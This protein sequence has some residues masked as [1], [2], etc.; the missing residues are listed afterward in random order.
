[1]ET[2]LE[3]AAV[4]PRY[5]RVVF[6]VLLCVSALM[7]IV[8]IRLRER[9]QDRLDAALDT[10]PL[11]APA[12]TQPSSVTL[13]LANDADGSTATSMRQLSLPAE[14]HARAR[15]LLNQL[16]TEYAKP[17]SAHPIATNPGID[18]VFLM[19]IAPASEG[20]TATPPKG[21]LAVVNLSGGLIQVHPSGIEPETLTLL[22]M[23]TTLNS[24]MP[25]ITQVRFL[26][27]G[28]PRETL[29]GHADLSR[30]YLASSSATP[31]VENQP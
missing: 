11:S 9:A 29:A 23:I 16:L 6:W 1:M 2:R 30:T 21:T 4:I 13:M 15:F 18:D 27:D 25:E 7:A 19:P 12:D 10:A 8:L 24:N 20:A 28:E 17:A 26:V 14:P 22:S 3:C 31:M 5:Q